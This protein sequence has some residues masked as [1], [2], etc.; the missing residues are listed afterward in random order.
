[1]YVGKDKPDVIVKNTAPAMQMLLELAKQA[2]GVEEVR[3]C[4]INSGKF[5]VSWDRTKDALEE[6][7]VA[8]GWKGSVQVWDSENS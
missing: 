1:M 4:K 5:G 8:K 3:M 2:D 6:I 7:T